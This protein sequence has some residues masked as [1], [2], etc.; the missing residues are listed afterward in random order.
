MERVGKGVP[1]QRWLEIVD[2]STES[3]DDE[4]E[5]DGD[6]NRMSPEQRLEIIIINNIIIQI[7]YYLN[8]RIYRV[9]S[10]SSAWSIKMEVTFAPTRVLHIE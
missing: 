7:I 2:V 6:D 5:D 8:H 1:E 9:G 10:Y 3:D 4:E